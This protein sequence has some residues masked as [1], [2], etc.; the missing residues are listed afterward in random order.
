MGGEFR[1]N[2]HEIEIDMMYVKQDRR[3]YIERNIRRLL[4]QL[5]SE[6]LYRTQY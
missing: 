4:L 6:N 2:L 3:Y 1:I 5:N